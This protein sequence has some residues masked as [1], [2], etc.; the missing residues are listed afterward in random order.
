MNFR[1]YEYLSVFI[2]SWLFVYGLTP[3]II[4]LANKINFVDKPEARK[5]HLKSVPLMGGLSVALGFIL[6]CVYD[7]VISPGRYFD[8]P[9]LGYLAGSVLIVFIGIIDDRRGMKPLIKLGGQILVSLTFIF[10]NFTFPELQ[11]MFGSI[12]VTLPLLLLWMVGLMNAMNFLDN[13]DGIISGMAGILG[14]GFFAFA[15]TNATSSNQNAMAL[16]ALISLSFAGSTFGFL[17]YNFN[18]A[19]IFLGDAG[20][21]F[22]GYFLSSMGI[23]MAQYAG[24]KYNDKFFYL[25]PVLLLSYAIFDISLVS[26]TRKRDG[27]HVMQGGKDHSTHRINTVLGSVRVT[28]AIIYTINVLIVLTSIMV[29]RIGSRE[30]LI[31][32]TMLF[33]I[34][35]LIFGHKLDQVPIVIPANQKKGK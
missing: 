19:K 9:M 14:L 29:F 17:P 27:R 2:M 34:F 21:M 5:M 30:L 26:F 7:V 28:A 8:A 4:K 35:F 16:I 12:Y 13:M 20:S 6:L 15:L 10:T 33:A 32:S 25:M 31:F 18:P 3:F 23:L 11:R 1:I 22:I 24:I